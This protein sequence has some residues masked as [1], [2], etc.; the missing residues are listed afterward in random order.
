ML[1]QYTEKM[2]NSCE[3]FTWQYSGIVRKKAD[4][5]AA[6]NIEIAYDAMSESYHE[7][8]SSVRY[9]IGIN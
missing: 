3:N 7:E 2:K 1:I 8:I 4:M 6:E 9:Q 5:E